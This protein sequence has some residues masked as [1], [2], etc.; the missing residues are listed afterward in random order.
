[1]S[2][3]RDIMIRFIMSVFWIALIVSAINYLITGRK[4]NKLTN[5]SFEP[6]IDARQSVFNDSVKAKA[7]Y[8]YINI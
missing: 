1:M 7:N 5:D 4:Q 2:N 3:E 6:A 8:G